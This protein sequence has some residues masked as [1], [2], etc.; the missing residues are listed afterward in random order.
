M[1]ITQ[2]A[3]TTN[4]VTYRVIDRLSAGDLAAIVKDARARKVP[5]TATVVL[6]GTNSMTLKWHN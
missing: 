2:N 4:S 5:N 1:E 3:T 6:G